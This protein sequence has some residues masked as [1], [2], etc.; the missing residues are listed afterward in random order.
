MAAM[1]K[2]CFRIRQDQVAALKKIAT[3][4][5]KSTKRNVTA[6]ELVRRGIDLV[7]ENAKGKTT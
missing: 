5:T 4:E 3:A 1:E 2:K 6:N 7:I